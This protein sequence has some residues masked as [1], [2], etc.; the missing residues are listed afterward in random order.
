MIECHGHSPY[1]VA[2]RTEAEAKRRDPTKKARR[3]VVEV[4]HRGFNGFRKPRVRYEKRE[5]GFVALRHL[6][7]AVIAFRTVELTVDV[8]RGRVPGSARSLP[9]PSSKWPLSV[10][11]ACSLKRM[12]REAARR[13]RPQLR[14]GAVA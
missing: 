2:R 14:P 8:V 7:A 11:R 4:C 1:V 6:A 5:R 10:N 12:Q 9:S 3:W 13:P